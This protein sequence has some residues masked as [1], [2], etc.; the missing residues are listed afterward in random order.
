MS[1]YRNSESTNGQD[2]QT[3]RRHRRMDK[4]TPDES[5]QAP[6]RAQPEQPAAPSAAEPQFVDAPLPLIN[7]AP[8]QPASGASVYD[9]ASLGEKRRRELQRPPQST[10]VHTRVT[11]TGYQQIVR[12]QARPNFQATPGAQYQRPAVPRANAE[13]QEEPRPRA[14]AGRTNEKLERDEAYERR[15]AERRARLEAEPDE[16]YDDEPPHRHTG[17]VILL[18]IAALIAV[19]V[20]VYFFL[21][22]GDS[23]II[24]KLND[25]KQ[26]ISGA[27]SKVAGLVSPTKEPAQVLSFTA[28]T[29]SGTTATR[30]I[31][32]ITTTQNASDVRLVDDAGEKLAASVKSNDKAETNRVWELT[33]LFEN[34]YTGAVYAAVEQDGVWT[35]SD[36][37]IAM[38]VALP[39]VAPT[40]TPTPTPT[41]IPLNVGA[42][43]I[44]QTGTPND[45]ADP[46]ADAGAPYQVA[47]SNAGPTSAPTPE[48]FTPPPATAEPTAEPTLEPVEEP[49]PEPVEEPTEAPTEEPTEEPTLEPTAE[50]TPEPD[51][52]PTPMP[53]LAA[54]GDSSSLKMTD[55]VYKGAKAQTD[56]RRE[57]SL[58]AVNPDNYAYW[59]GGVL[60]F[61]GDSFRRN[62]AF[63]TAEVA[64]DTLSVL[65][66]SELGSLR[67][68]DGTVYGVGWTGQPAIVKWSKDVREIMNIKDEKKGVTAL[69]EVI[70]AG[71]D[72]KVRFLDLT[73][74]QETRDP[75]D[76]GFPLKSSVSVDTLG[77]P[78]ISFGQGVSKLSNKTGA[79]GYYLYN[80]LDCTRLTFI[81]GRAND[82]QK[83]YGTNGAFD[84]TSLFLW[85]TDTMVIAGENGLL[86][87]VELNTVFTPEEKSLTVKPNIIYLKS[88]A[89]AAKDT[90]TSIESSVAMYDKYVFMAD[91]YGA[92]RCVDTDTMRT[93]WALDTGDNTDASPALDFDENNK[94][95]LYTGNTNNARLKKK[96]VSIRR[97]DAM[98]GEV[99]W[100]YE[101]SC[102]QDSKTELAG[103]KASPIIGENA[104]DHLVIFT[105][106]RVNGGGS[107]MLALN[108]D[109]GTLAWQY[110][111]DAE[112]ISS[113]V[114]VYNEAGDAWIIQG[115]LDGK[116]HMLDG[117]SGAY[118]SSLALEG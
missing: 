100:T 55:T 102:T 105:V 33:A 27:V 23:G 2:A 114:A 7:D 9:N 44:D 19:L 38:T 30:Y 67:T 77:R 75:I 101:I 17:R 94:L 13:E 24:G 79:I 93:I 92:L 8:E 66:K 71:M 57:T 3:V 4:Y 49:T 82:S 107:T 70:F 50:P 63:G 12:Q 25:I 76:I 98:T 85:N 87:T 48:A 109:T 26:N 108:K 28:S 83:Q 40:P 91:K 47:A 5:T 84:G 15:M 74:G 88:K 89:N 81:N 86:Y 73:D 113:P 104:I 96:D 51:P 111:M 110:H 60:T 52:T 53:A 18:I 112:A 78:I 6:Q 56:Y 14:Q 58:A 32:Y 10:D 22:A 39:T 118:L 31:F 90:Q 45:A 37:S 65:W 72:G 34:P 35:T 36:R 95:W 29:N 1:D 103:C 62:A 64:S 46:T 80:L 99:N 54:S 16:E 68:S 115:D 61:R 69:R 43:I 106:N 21:P 42:Q 117:Q 59:Q 41:T 11:Q 116:L 97:I 20:G